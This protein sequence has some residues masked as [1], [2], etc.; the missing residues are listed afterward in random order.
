MLTYLQRAI[1]YSA[2]A[3]EI[4][5]QQANIFI[6]H[7]T[8]FL[9]QRRA[10]RDEGRS[11]GRL[12]PPSPPRPP[13][14]PPPAP[15]IS[16]KSTHSMYTRDRDATRESESD[17]NG[18]AAGPP[19]A[20]SSGR[21]ESIGRRRSPPAAAREGRQRGAR[22]RLEEHCFLTLKGRGCERRGKRGGRGGTQ[23][24]RGSV[25]PPPPLSRSDSSEHPRSARR[26]GR[27]KERE[28]TR[29]SSRGGPYI[30]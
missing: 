12:S 28:I 17:G 5:V 20:G 7:F 18:R 3:I 8:E 22:E 29:P 4:P 2:L 26:S 9:L 19:R 10:G 16:M 1:R 21:V 23:W 24:R 14:S 6:Q 25:S 15:V 27:R 11:A 13:T 30:T